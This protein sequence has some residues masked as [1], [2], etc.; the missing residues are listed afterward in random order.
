MSKSKTKAA[1][2][3]AAAEAGAGFEFTLTLLEPYRTL[4]GDR[5]NVQID[6]HSA[7]RGSNCLTVA[8][9]IPLEV[10]EALALVF[11]RPLTTVVRTVHS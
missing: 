6:Y 11:L 10:A 2:T 3:L 4:V 5:V 1:A 7:A 9:G 8:T